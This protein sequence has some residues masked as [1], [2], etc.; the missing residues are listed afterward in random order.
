MI[1]IQLLLPPEKY[2]LP[3][4]KQIGEGENMQL[5]IPKREETKPTENKIW[6][7]QKQIENRKEISI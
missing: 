5:K 4:Q 2:W 1:D 6:L 3:R 7:Y